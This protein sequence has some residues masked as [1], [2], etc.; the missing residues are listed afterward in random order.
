M[1]AGY[2]VIFARDLQQTENPYIPFKNQLTERFL[3]QGLGRFDERAGR[4]RSMNLLDFDLN[5]RDQ[6]FSNISLPGI[7]S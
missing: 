3:A 1:N 5:D 2:Q 7:T 6:A 4:S